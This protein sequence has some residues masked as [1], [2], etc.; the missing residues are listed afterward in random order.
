[1]MN[2][3]KR[4]KKEFLKFQLV[5]NLFRSLLTSVLSK[6]ELSLLSKAC[7]CI[8]T[9]PTAFVTVLN[10]IT[11]TNNIVITSA[12]TTTRTST[13]TVVGPTASSQTT[14]TPVFNV[15]YESEGCTL[16][17]GGFSIGQDQFGLSTAITGCADH[18]LRNTLPT[19]AR[20][21]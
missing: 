1:M 11:T 18:C 9:T 12:T 16:A 15:V 6:F 14:V 4:N 20:K 13:T 3:R 8:V 21:F 17:G 19:T 5:S 10:P 7:S 2:G